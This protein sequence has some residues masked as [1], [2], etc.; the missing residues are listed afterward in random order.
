MIGPLTFLNPWIL[1][2]LA[3]LP[4]LWFLLRVTPPA[5]R[6]IV[7]PAARFLAG[8]APKE[9]T[10]RKTPW[11]VLL[12][13]LMA[14]ALIIFALA[15]PVLNA[16][17]MLTGGGPVRI[18]IDNGW[19]AARNWAQ[20][21]QAASDIVE[22]AARERRP[23]YIVTTAPEPGSAKPMS[24]GP[25][26]SGPAN[27]MLRGV[28]TRP[29]PANYDAAADSLIVDTHGAESFFLSH[30]G[31]DGNPDRLLR[32]LQHQGGLTFYEPSA[33]RWPLLLRPMANQGSDTEFYLDAPPG[34]ANGVPVSIETSGAGGRTID[35]TQARLNTGNLPQKIKIDLPET[36]RG[37]ISRIA[38]SGRP[39]A[40]G[41]LLSDDQEGRKTVGIVTPDSNDAETP[42]IEAGF[43]LSRALSPYADLRTGKVAELLKAKPAVLILPDTGAMA[44]DDLNVLEKWVRDGGLLLRFAG[45]NMSKGDAFL[46]PVKLRS[47]GRALSGSL[48]WDKP[49]HLAPF[50]ES[51]P[52]N[53]LAIPPDLTVR[54]QILAEPEDALE[55][56]VWAALE[57]GT[58]LITADRLDNGLLV[59]VHTTATPAWS[60]LALSGLFVQILRRTVGMAGPGMR[61]TSSG[62]GALQPLRVVDGFGNLTTPDP[63]VEPIAA[64]KAE[65]QTVDAK[66]PPGIYGRAGL[67]RALNLGAGLPALK[68]FDS[69][70]SGT[71][72]LTFGQAN[73][74]DLMPP[75]LGMALTLFILD[76]LAMI[77]LQAGWRIRAARF[78]ALALMIA[79]T[80]HPAAAQEENNDVKAAGAIYLAY[81]RSGDPAVDATAQAGLDGVVTVLNERTS[82]EPAGA[83]AIDPEKDT[84]AFYPLIYWPVIESAQPLSPT[85]QKRV[86]DYLD[87]GGTILFDTGNRAA[88]ALQRIGSSLNIPPLIHMPSDHVLTKSFYLM[89]S[90]PGK[91]ENGILW[92]E[93]QSASGRDGVSS[94]IV[95]A[96]DWA[97]AWAAQRDPS[98]QLP[99]GERQK[100]LAARFGVNLVMYALTG[101]YKADQVHLPQIMERLGR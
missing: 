41:I 35:I 51:S 99:G 48:T 68:N 23:V 11:W 63:T 45:P 13:R 28:A 101:N 19:G 87:H 49:L 12:M 92:V 15:R 53:G 71:A 78:A 83:V 44:A 93:D 66:H 22:H 67:T 79:L 95:G 29:W 73:E 34:A 57:D 64:D 97:S 43:Y 82:V 16:N 50:P 21:M 60:D 8:I 72:R 77:A 54:Q 20:T 7:F 76:W 88:D 3:F 56:K 38:L 27:A 24:V 65:T 47:G 62:T 6:R 37:Q 70:P 40:G 94:V 96:N 1:A 89:D 39:G 61:A 85:A 30:G 58:P 100:E 80:A 4:V 2:G 5:P 42:L 32:A 91:F 52:Y 18:V 46:T 55:K 14:A 86:Q 90:M 75:L 59:L 33:E 25:L 84:L 69:L 98:I 81:V 26:A 17:D 31:Q 74:R 9:H 36:L 10:A